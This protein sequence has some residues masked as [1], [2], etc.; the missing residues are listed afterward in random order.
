MYFNGTK[1]NINHIFPCITL[2]FILF[3]NFASSDFSNTLPEDKHEHCALEDIENNKHSFAEDYSYIQLR[4][5]V[6]IKRDNA[7]HTD[8]YYE[9]IDIEN[10]ERVKFFFIET[11]QRDH[12]RK[13]F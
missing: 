11:S 13:C 2:L 8:S 3:V 9:N 7:K 4:P 10:D 6:V 12:L 1:K 5:I